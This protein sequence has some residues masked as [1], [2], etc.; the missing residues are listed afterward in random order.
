MA[1]VAGRDADEL[2]RALAIELDRADAQA[3][4]L[5]V[6]GGSALSLLGLVIRPTKDIDVVALAA[7]KGPVIR[8][9]KADPLPEHL[10]EAAWAVA[11][12]F[13]IETD[14]LNP[15]QPTSSTRGFRW[16]LNQGW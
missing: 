12:Q 13:G 10:L 2:F 14:W 3:T 8:V 4:E 5:C 7:S 11:R 1:T 6:I 15:G 9:Y 16:G